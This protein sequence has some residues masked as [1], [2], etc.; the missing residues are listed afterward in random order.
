VEAQSAHCPRCGAA[1]VVSADPVPAQVAEWAD[2]RRR[3]TQ[4]LLE[5]IDWRRP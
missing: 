5:L 2:A 4:E 1:Y 3:R